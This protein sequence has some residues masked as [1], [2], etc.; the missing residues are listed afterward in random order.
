M[1]KSVTRALNFVSPLEKLRRRLRLSTTA[2]GAAC[3]IDQ[4]TY[5]R[6]E[7]GAGASREM[8]E[9]IAQYFDDKHGAF[10]TELHILYPERYP[11]FLEERKRAKA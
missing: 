3:G 5:F 9:R 10:L 2:V 8:A 7:K 1:T 11:N 6:I 4:S